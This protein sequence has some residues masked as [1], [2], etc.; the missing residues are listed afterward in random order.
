VDKRVSSFVGFVP[1][2]EPRL[3]ILVIMDE[4]EEK[5]YG[6][7]VAAPVFSRIA[8]QALR[9]LKIAPTEPGLRNPLPVHVDKK[10]ALPPKA[11]AGFRFQEPGNEQGAPRMPDCVGMSSRQVLQTMGRTGVNIKLK[12]HG[13]VVE[14][15]PSA[16]RPIEFGSEVWVRLAPPA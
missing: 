14:Q 11:V 9:Y 2:E 5:T 13:R 7:L 15:S 16:G 6:G 10:G 4:P 1:A 12:G 8:D 3:V